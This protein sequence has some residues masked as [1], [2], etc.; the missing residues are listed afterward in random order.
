[1]QRRDNFTKNLRCT[2][3]A[4]GERDQEG[5]SIVEMAIVLPVLILLLIAVIDFARIMDA[6]IVLTNAAREGARFRSL[7]PSLT[8]PD[9]QQ[10]V[11]NDVLGSGTNV[12]HMADFATSNVAVQATTDAV[13][14]T[15]SYDFQ[16]W[17]GGMIRLDTVHLDREAVMPVF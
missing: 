10:M 1:M 15:V 2:H 7:D 12:T 4:G 16:L 13:T 6:S 9:V 17:F 8:I 14:V 11:V 5:Q 3:A